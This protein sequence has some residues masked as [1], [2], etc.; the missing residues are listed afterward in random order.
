MESGVQLVFIVAKAQLYWLLL[1][2]SKQD[3]FFF[4]LPCKEGCLLLINP[5]PLLLLEDILGQMQDFAF[6]IIELQDCQ[7]HFS[8]L[9]E[10]HPQINIIY[11]FAVAYI[12]QN[13]LNDCFDYQL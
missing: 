3:Q 5:Q 1:C 7:A 6:A 10:I 2:Y 9:C 8:I 12:T 11:K 4:S 13:L